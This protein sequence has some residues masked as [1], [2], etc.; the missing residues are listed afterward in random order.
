MNKRPL[1]IAALLWAAILWLLGL[2]G[3]P[4]FTWKSPGLPK[5]SQCENA[6]ITGI[7]Y[8]RDCHTLNT[9]LYIKHANLILESNPY[10]MDSIKVTI[11]NEKIKEHL[12]TGSYLS[13]RGNLEEIPFPANPGQFH[14][15]A[16]YYARKVKWYLKAE[17][18]HVLDRKKDKLLCVQGYVK[19][20]TEQSIR[21]VFSKKEA[22]ILCAMLLGD[23]G[24]MEKEDS[25][26]FGLISCSHILAISGTHISILG[27]GFYRLLGRF[28][29][30]CGVSAVMTVG[31]IFFY[32]GLTGNSASALRAEVMFAVSVGAILAG[33][34]YDFLSALS[35][36]GILLL[37][38]SP[39]YLYDSGFLLSFGAVL[40]LGVMYPV[41]FS[42]N[43]RK[44]RKGIFEKLK[45][46]LTEGLRAGISV[47][48]VLLPIV[49]YYFYEIPVWGIVTN[50]FILPTAGAA[51]VSGAFGALFGIAFTEAG[52]LAGVPCVL[53]LAGY[54]KAGEIVQYLPVS[55]W[56]TGRPPLWK[57]FVYYSILIVILWWKK[58]EGKT[59]NTRI[60]AGFAISVLL[61]AVFLVW[62][63]PE[64]DMKITFL[65]V[66]Q[67]DCACIQNGTSGCYLVD[68]GS[69][70]IHGVGNYRILPFLKAA[71]VQR[72]D[73]VFLSHMD[74]DHINGIQELLEMIKNRETVV[75]I[76][77][78]FLSLCEETAETR[79]HLETAAKEAGCQIIYIRKGTKI[80]DK[81]MEIE[82]LAPAKADLGSNESS[83]VLRIRKGDMKV[84]FTGDV[85]GE[86]ERLLLEELALLGKRE[87][88][89]CQI[90]KAAHHG[91][92]N[93]T[94]EEFLNRV[95]PVAAILSFGE[96]NRYGHPHQ[97]L[98]Q[99][100][101]FHGVKILETAR[102]GAIC[103][104]C[105]GKTAG[106]SFQY[107]GTMIK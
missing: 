104:V 100:L 22:G 39:L 89:A 23:K 71:G 59:K 28:Y 8:K 65:D 27:W 101:A 60:Q 72:I 75:R 99:R 92:K 7:V 31:A 68:G 97:E 62:K 11:K 25:L 102:Q 37:A 53:I 98:L 20:K 48:C 58:R 57:C 83:Q 6:L 64:K 66:G 26:L 88:T 49:M 90:L 10:S 55:M 96:D 77:K 9:S 51:L 47:W 69:S 105:D 76:S 38:E 1:C 36:A 32:G 3:I 24:N 12:N 15:R 81:D 56:I 86:G 19:E 70:S 73:G 84:L 16:Y 54:Q 103:V 61:G 50:L 91:S 80:K 82:C 44:G 40:G 29:I 33:R 5:G 34:T 14:E 95:K 30:P 63:A 85:E 94:S 79:K 67:G 45:N 52:K 74:E 41:L 46:L 87:D 78:I 18:I 13:I 43:K 35:L 4:A 93:S 17:E 107:E 106:I 21:R 2:A 42:Q